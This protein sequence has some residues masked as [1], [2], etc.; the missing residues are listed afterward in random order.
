VKRWS[1]KW[2]LRIE[3]HLNLTFSVV[4]Y[5]LLFI[6]AFFTLRHFRGREEFPHLTVEK[7]PFSHQVETD[8]AIMRVFSFNPSTG[9]ISFEAAIRFN[10]DPR[11]VDQK[12]IERFFFDNGAITFKSVPQSVL[13]EDGRIIEELIIKATVAF[14]LNL[15][16]FPFDDHLVALRLTNNSF[17]NDKIVYT[18]SKKSFILPEKR[19]LGNFT[20]KE[21]W[22]EYGFKK[23]P[24]AAQH[25]PNSINRNPEIFFCMKLKQHNYNRGLMI[26]FPLLLMFFFA[27]NTISFVS[28]T[29]WELAFYCAFGNLST[30]VM[31]RLVIADFLVAT[32]YFTF[33]DYLFYTLLIAADVTMSLLFFSYWYPKSRFLPIVRLIAIPFLNLFLILGVAYYLWF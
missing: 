3:S 24:F 12:L 10:F 15:S 27:V 23:L 21:A 2:R 25:F 31:F 14:R 6:F 32:N 9:E 19:I 22:T 8:L 13:L 28:R 20:V 18:T 30:L 26:V 4:T 33:A 7:A 1:K 16:D 17:G 11:V 5:L 29:D